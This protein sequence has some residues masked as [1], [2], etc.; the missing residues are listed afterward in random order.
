MHE[1]LPCCVILLPTII[2]EKKLSSAEQH[3]LE[4]HSH[5]PQEN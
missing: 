2:T 4:Q 1:E 5:V 3:L